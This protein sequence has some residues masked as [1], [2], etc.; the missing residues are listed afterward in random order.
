[1]RGLIYLCS[2]ASLSLPSFASELYVE[3]YLLSSFS[4]RLHGEDKLTTQLNSLGLKTEYNQEVFYFKFDGQ[5]Q[6][7]AVYDFHDAY[8]EIAKDAYGTRIWLDEAYIGTATEN[9]DFTLGYQ[10]IFWGTADDLRVLD[11]VNPLDLKD[12]VLFDIDEYKISLPMF[13]AE[14]STDNGWDLEFIYIFNFEENH[15]PEA[16]SEFSIPGISELESDEPKGAEFGFSAA[17]FM[18]DADIAFYA[19]NGYNDNPIF[20]FENQLVALTHKRE[21]MF[22]TSISRPVADWVVRS[23]IAFVMDRTHTLE[24]FQLVENNVWQGLLGLDYLYGDWL[25]TMQLSD[26]FI[27]DWQ[28]NFLNDKKHAPVYTLSAD[29]NTLDGMLTTR[30]A[31]SY[32]DSN[33]G[34]G[35]YQTKLTYIATEQWKLQL[36]LDVL[37]G[38]PGNFFGTYR[39]KDRIWLATTYT[40]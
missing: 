35:L 14:T 29:V 16:G 31:M 23:E 3:S 9:W 5:L 19:F 13:R 22:G 38:N 6:Y 10:K 36:N 34:G 21:T 4:T 30:F 27:Q 11:V 39:E 32:A 26:S 7:D 24:D 2:L 33:G 37:S 18:F 12:F 40:F 20:T 28:E 1:M 17:S 25:F 8:S 15:L